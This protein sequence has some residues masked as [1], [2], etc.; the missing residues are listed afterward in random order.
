MHQ[1]QREFS[2]CHPKID[3]SKPNHRESS[4]IIK[5]NKKFGNRNKRKFFK[6]SKEKTTQGSAMPL[7][8]SFKNFQANTSEIKDYNKRV[9]EENKLTKP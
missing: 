1:S 8:Q 9:K 3:S 2:N 4:G 6:S 5:K 7:R